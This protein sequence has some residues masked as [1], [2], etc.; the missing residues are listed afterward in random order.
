MISD[1]EVVKILPRSPG[2]LAL[3]IEEKFRP[4]LEFLIQPPC[5][6]TL[7]FWSPLNPL[8]A[9]SG[10]QICIDVFYSVKV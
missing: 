3:N 2:L 7:G 1:S 5:L 6:H 9:L 10:P 4:N 8:V